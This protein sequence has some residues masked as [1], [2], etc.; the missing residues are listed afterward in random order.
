MVFIGMTEW[1]SPV[2]HQS[3]RA[4]QKNEAAGMVPAAVVLADRFP[5]YLIAFVCLSFGSNGVP[6]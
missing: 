6:I 5:T 1:F 4:D 3:W 2:T